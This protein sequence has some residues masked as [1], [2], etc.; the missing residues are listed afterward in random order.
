M[1]TRERN[2][3]FAAR[4]CVTGPEVSGLGPIAALF[5]RIIEVRYCTG[6]W[7][8]AQIQFT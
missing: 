7:T 4:P 6:F 8:P 2:G 5:R 1:T 3:G